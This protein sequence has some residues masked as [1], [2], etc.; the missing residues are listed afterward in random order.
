[1]ARK[2]AK[3]KLNT[4]KPLPELKAAPEKWGG[5]RMLIPHPLDVDK[6]MKTVPF[7]SVIIAQ[8]LRKYLANSH[9]V[10]ICCPMVTGIFI[11]LSAAA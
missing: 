9:G 6:V 5:G 11:N 7:G 2:T 8:D 4:T 3:E 1:M 10:D